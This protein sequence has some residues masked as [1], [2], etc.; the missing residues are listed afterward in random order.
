MKSKNQRIFESQKRQQE[1][2][3]KT[4]KIKSIT[5][6]N[7]SSSFGHNTKEFLLNM[8]FYCKGEISAPSKNA[9]CEKRLNNNE[10]VIDVRK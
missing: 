7:V 6:G 2:A 10:I 4:K 3:R 1:I 9:W 8:G 5:S